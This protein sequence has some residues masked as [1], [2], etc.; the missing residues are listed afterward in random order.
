[1]LVVER[2]VSSGERLPSRTIF[3]AKRCNLE[4]RHLAPLK[5]R[6]EEQ[7]Y[8]ARAAVGHALDVSAYGRAGD[9]NAELGADG[10]MRERLLSRSSAVVRHQQ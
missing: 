10:D 1:M 6:G 7:S 4:R 2:M 8:S 9:R 3:R 5:L